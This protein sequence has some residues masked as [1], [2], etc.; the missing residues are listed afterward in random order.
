MR[1]LIC[2][3]TILR[4]STRLCP[5]LLPHPCPPAVLGKGYQR[6]FELATLRLYNMNTV[7]GNCEHGGRLWLCNAGLGWLVAVQRGPPPTAR[8]AAPSCGPCCCRGRN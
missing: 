6:P 3:T 1:L 7:L 4:C 8:P 5:T 2:L